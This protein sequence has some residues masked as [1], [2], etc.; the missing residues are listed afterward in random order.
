VATRVPDPFEALRLDEVML[1]P[2]YDWAFES[3]G[4]NGLS[5]SLSTRSPSLVVGA[6]HFCDALTSMATAGA[7]IHDPRTGQVVGALGL[8]CSASVAN[9]LLLPMARRAARDI[10]QEMIGGR[11]RHDR[12]LEE[13]FLVARR[14]SRRPLALVSRD[15]LLT[16]AAA[17]RLIDPT[18]QPRLWELASGRLRSNQETDPVF[19]AE[20]GTAF[21]LVLEA[22]V[23]GTEL[24]AVVVRFS[25]AE[26]RN[27]ELCAPT[28][29][30]PRTVGWD[31]LTEAELSVTELVAEGLTNR[32]IASKLFISPYTVDSHLRHIFQKLDIS[33]RVDLVRIATSRAAAVSTLV[34]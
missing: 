15:R 32:R 6:E 9:S 34:A 7:P 27:A 31:N 1:V 33:S 17:A 16:N 20:D 21:P 2:G 18:D 3:A 13:A 19:V 14:R 23:D 10:G 8:V 5:D 25:G 29:L 4:T 12:L 24:A 22:V 26:G 11:T 28:R 30:A